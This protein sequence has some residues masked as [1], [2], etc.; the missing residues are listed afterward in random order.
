MSKPARNWLLLRGLSREQRHWAGFPERLSQTLGSKVVCLDLPG[1]GTELSRPSPSKIQDITDDLR[2]RFSDLRGGQSGFGI[3]AVSLGGMIAL[4]WVH[5]FP[6]DFEMAAIVNSSAGNLSRPQDRLRLQNLGPLMAMLRESDPMRRE[7]RLLKL[8]TN[9][10]GEDANLAREFGEV[11]R[12]A[13]VS[14]SVMRA[15]VIAAMRFVT[16]E[17]VTKPLEFFVSAKDRFVD[18]SCTYRLAERYLSPV[19][20]HPNAGHELPLD[21]PDWTIEEMRRIS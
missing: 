13:P 3:F 4:D 20:V 16:P 12:S 15:Q 1:V 14:A 17:E 19:R 8:I 6:A 7:Q 18:P 9:H 21:D 5:R 10:R 2:P 11:A